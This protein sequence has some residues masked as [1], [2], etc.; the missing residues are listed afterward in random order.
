MR[1]MPAL[2]H[3]SSVRLKGFAIARAVGG[4]TLARVACCAALRGST[5]A[6]AAV[7]ARRERD[8]RSYPDAERI[9]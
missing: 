7:S 3:D 1:S 5:L 6:P 2:R 8:L 4:S 9:D